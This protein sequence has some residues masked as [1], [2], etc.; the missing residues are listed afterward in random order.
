MD[1]LQFASEVLVSG[2]GIAGLVL[3]A[4]HV[5]NA[6][7]VASDAV[8]TLSDVIAAMHGNLSGVLGKLVAASPTL[9]TDGVRLAAD[10]GAA[11]ADAKAAKPTQVVAEAVTVTSKP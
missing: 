2:V 7:T 8:A 3:S 9:L 11:P 1:Y 4:F 6:N 5:K 10:F